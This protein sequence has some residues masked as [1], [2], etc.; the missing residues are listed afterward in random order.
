MI[1]MQIMC[2]TEHRRMAGRENG[3]EQQ[4]V[5]GKNLVYHPCSST[6]FFRKRI[7]SHTLEEND[8]K[9]NKGGRKISHL[10]F[11]DDTDALAEKNQETQALY[12]LKVPA[13]LAQCVT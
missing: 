2:S 12:L 13:K 3:S 4:L 8:G 9:V 5:L 7:L 1:S 11:A 6:S 10:R